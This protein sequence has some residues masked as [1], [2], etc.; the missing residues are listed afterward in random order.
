MPDLFLERTFESPI[1]RS[2]VL[3]MADIGRSCFQI[4]RVEWCVSLL[5]AGGHKMVCRFRAPDAESLRIAL[6]SA[7]APTGRL[8]AGTVHD[9]PNLSKADRASANVAI[10]RSFD[11]PVP[12]EEI[13]T[14]EQQ[15]WCARAY[16]VTFLRTYVS[17]DR[18][19]MICLY[20]APD[21]ESVRLAQ[22]FMK[23]PVEAIW[24]FTAIRP[25]SEQGQTRV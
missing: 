11:V 23:M 6:R 20:R 2:D 14:A 16:N 8:W 3:A 17:N 12:V 9:G 18:K 21:A 10:E 5:A 1:G 25:G 22:R 19:R 13:E 7:K 15:G 4:H 24:A